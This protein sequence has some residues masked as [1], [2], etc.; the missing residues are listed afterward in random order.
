MFRLLSDSESTRVAM[1]H[2]SGDSQ[3]TPV[4]IFHVSGD[5][6]PT[7]VATSHVWGDPEYT[8]VAM[9]HA[10]DDSQPTLVATSHVSG[11]SESIFIMM[12]KCIRG[13]WV[14]IC[15]YAHV[16]I[17][18]LRVIHLLQ[19]TMYHETHSVRLSR[20]QKCQ[21]RD[22]TLVTMLKWTSPN[23]QPCFEDNSIAHC[24]Q[25]TT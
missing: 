9:S 21:V 11:D 16:C 12:P 25:S 19:R 7:H 22:S 17:R 14:N 15:R 24:A 2:V 20:C 8:R 5:S 23:G 6:G 10:S 13:L 18:Q 1:S 3:P 4:A